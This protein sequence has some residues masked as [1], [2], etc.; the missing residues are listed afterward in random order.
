M[1]PV[2]YHPQAR[3]EVIA[4]A[5]YYEDRAVGLGADFLLEAERTEGFLAQFPA[6]GRQLP[7]TIRR[8]SLQRFPYHLIYRIEPQRIFVLAIAHHRRRPGYWSSR[9]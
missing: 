5:V 1:L 8:V 9:Q 2:E 6:M 4:T 3:D 7:D